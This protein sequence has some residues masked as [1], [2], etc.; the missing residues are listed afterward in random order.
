MERNQETPHLDDYTYDSSDES[1]VDDIYDV[2]RQE[3]EDN[4]DDV[5]GGDVEDAVCYSP[6]IFMGWF[7]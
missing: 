1:D 2:R 4:G 3:K 5:T 6:L 7:A